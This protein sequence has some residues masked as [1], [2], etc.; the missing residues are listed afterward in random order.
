M[1][2]IAILDRLNAL[3]APVLLVSHEPEILAHAG[4]VIALEGPPLKTV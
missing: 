3:P 2:D 1:I 4:T